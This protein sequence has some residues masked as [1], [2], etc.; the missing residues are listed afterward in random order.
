MTV[1]RGAP[2][3]PANHPAGTPQKISI[4]GPVAMTESIRVGRAPGPAQILSLLGCDGRRVHL[5]Q[6]KQKQN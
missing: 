4:A 6:W 5:R 3:R 2:M 1:T